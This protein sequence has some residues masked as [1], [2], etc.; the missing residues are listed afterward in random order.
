MFDDEDDEEGDNYKKNKKKKEKF[1]SVFASADEFASLLEDEGSSKYAPGS[2]NS[3]MNKDKAG[4][5]S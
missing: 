4:K 2:S 1:G 5:F 3:L